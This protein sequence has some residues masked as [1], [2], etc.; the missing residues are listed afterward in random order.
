[1]RDKRPFYIGG[2]W[3]LSDSAKDMPV[4]NPASEQPVAV[5][6]LGTIDDVDRAVAAAK[7]AFETWSTVS[8][9]DRI[10][11]LERTIGV[12]QRRTDEM[13]EAIRLEMGAPVRFVRENQTPSGLGHL[14]STL[15]A[16]RSFEFERP[17]P[18]RGSVL[19]SEPI[20]VCG[21][22]TP[23]NWP[24]NQIVAKVAPALAAGCTMVLKPSELRL[25]PRCFS[26]RF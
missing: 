16:L 17:S 5:I 23:W 9:D 8:V 2:E 1:M 21:L 18:R 22:I 12:Y 4:I 19:R 15:D 3:I 20:G 10:A 11:L 6:S 13:D 24:I 14:Q 26:P 7:A 25:C